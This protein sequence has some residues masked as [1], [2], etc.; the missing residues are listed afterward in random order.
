ERQPDAAVARVAD[1]QREPA[2]ELPLSRQVPLLYVRRLQVLRRHEQ[3]A[4][5]PP[6]RVAHRAGVAGTRGGEGRAPRSHAG[7]EDEAARRVGDFVA[8]EPAEIRSEAV[9]RL[10][11]DA[12]LVLR[13]DGLEEAAVIDAVTAADHELARLARDL[14]QQ[15]ILR[16]RRPGESDA[17]LDVVPVV[18][19]AVLEAVF[20]LFRRSRVL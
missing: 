6:A 7:R 17:R 5:Q 16:R 10:R 12:Q 8:A 14:V 18:F 20:D 13:E 3:R 9:G 15:T 19:V 2:S 4:E 1:L 11:A